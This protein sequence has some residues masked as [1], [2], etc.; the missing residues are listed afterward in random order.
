M[1]FLSDRTRIALNLFLPKR[2]KPDPA[3][4]ITEADK[5]MS[6]KTVVLTGGTAGIGR[7]AAAQLYGM[8]ANLVLLGRKQAEGDA[9][10]REL[11]ATGGRGSAR[12]LICDLASM[13]SVK[14]CAERIL[15]DNERID[16][17]VNGAGINA[18]KTVITEDGFELNWAVNCF[19]PI[20]L[21]RLLTDRIR[22]SAPARIVYLVTNLTFLDRIDPDEIAARP[23]FASDEPYV[24]SKLSGSMMMI[25]L[26][27]RLAGDGVTVNYLHPGNIRSDLLRHLT[28]AERVMGHVMRLMASPT[29]VGADRVVRLAVSSEFE[30]VT[31][32]YLVE[33]TVKPAHPEAQDAHKRAR[34]AQITDKALA[35][36][37]PAPD[38]NG[39]PEGTRVA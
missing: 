21:T 29:E 28:G 7:V 18:T 19:G 34:I 30:G 24:E 26:A 20:L 37:L 25:D 14:A 1:P 36:W 16:V 22:A 9:V 5:D 39:G 6:G 2:R 38:G 3:H 11:T 15:A 10:I 23:D 8:G 33:D 12:F 17:L 31:G 35:R 27:A 4:A 13:D 32:A